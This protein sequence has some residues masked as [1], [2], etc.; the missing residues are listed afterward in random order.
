MSRDDLVKGQRASLWLPVAGIAFAAPF[1][2]WFAIGDHSG[3]PSYEFGPYQVGPESGYVVGGVATIVAAVALAV[4]IIRARRGVVDLRMWAVVATLAMAGA[5]GAAGWRA[6]TSG[7]SGSD[8][9]GPVVILLDPL[10]IAG[11]LVGTVWIAASGEHR[12]P[13][14][15]WLLTGAAVLVAPTLYA[16]MFALSTYDDAAGFITAR[17]YADVRVGQTR[18]AVH[19]RLGRQGEDLAYAVFQPGAPGSFCDYYIETN[20]GHAYQLCFRAGVL[21]S[22]ATKTYPVD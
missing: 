15:T 7:Y 20:G 18:S 10:L 14:R 17:Q 3:G 2:A 4:L 6:V 9:G 1:L 21:I 19:D 13:R 8:I 5:L 12:Q 11:L 22:K 16:V